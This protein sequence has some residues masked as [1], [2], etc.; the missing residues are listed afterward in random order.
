M[1]TSL[2]LT[3]FSQASRTEA[4]SPQQT[5][6][7]IAPPMPGPC[8]LTG[9]VSSTF[10]TLAMILRQ[11]GLLAP[12]PQS[13]ERLMSSPSERATSRLS[14][15]AKATP[16]RTAWVMSVRVVSIVMPTKVPRASVSF[17]GERSPIR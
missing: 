3:S 5:M 15:M 4:Y 16:S 2:T 13:M 7:S 11:S 9:R 8:S 1:T 17:I 6:A 14:R 12:P 10:S